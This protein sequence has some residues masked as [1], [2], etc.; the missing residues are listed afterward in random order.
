MKSEVRNLK[1]LSAGA[2]ANP[3][4]ALKLLAAIIAPVILLYVSI[5]GGAGLPWY[6]LVVAALGFLAILFIGFLMFT[7]P[8]R[9]AEIS[10]SPINR[11]ANTH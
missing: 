11:T 3:T 4:S 8:N 5:R 10:I 9:Q 6:L 1:L 7:R 2:F